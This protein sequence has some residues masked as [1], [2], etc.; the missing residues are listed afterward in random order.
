[1]CLQSMPTN[2]VHLP[3]LVLSI[4][5]EKTMTIAVPKLREMDTRTYRTSALTVAL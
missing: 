2:G 1:M 5:Q 4:S 3:R